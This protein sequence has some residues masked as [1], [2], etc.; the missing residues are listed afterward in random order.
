[1]K[2]R[3]LGFKTPLAERF[4]PK[5]NKRGPDECWL[6][7]GVKVRGGY[8]QIWDGERTIGAHRA[9][10]ILDG[11]NLG[12]LDVLHKCNNP[13]CVNPA[14]LRA[15]TEAENMQDAI[16]AGTFIHHHPGYGEENANVLLCEDAVIQIRR[17]YKAGGESLASL[18][19]EFSVSP[20]TIAKCIKRKTWKHVK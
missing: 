20:S 3:K 12:A 11:R 7:L 18:G 4:W 15:G 10:L 8:G 5:V 17:R 9:A 14:H 13:S 19:R 16:N 6:W 1:M 2:S